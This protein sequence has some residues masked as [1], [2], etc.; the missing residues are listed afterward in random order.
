MLNNPKQTD[1]VTRALAA[2]V[3]DNIG[4]YHL[5]QCYPKLKYKRPTVIP[6]QTPVDIENR[7]KMT[8]ALI[9]ITRGEN[10]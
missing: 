4:H 10:Y 5:R 8:L 7:I 6:K 2:T 1:S 9:A 3:R